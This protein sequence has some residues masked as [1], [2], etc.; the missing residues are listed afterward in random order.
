MT[1]STLEDE[2]LRALHDLR[3]VGT[4]AEAHLDAVC[5]VAANLFDVPIALVNLVDEATVWIKA[6]YGVDPA[7]VPRSDAFCHQTIEAV[8]GD[9]LVLP[10]LEKSERW[11][12][13]SLVRGGPNARF[14][15]GVPLALESGVNIGTLCIMDT[16]PR[17][18]FGAT[19][20]S[21]LYD[22]ASIVESH[23]RLHEARIARRKDDERYRL[24]ADNSTD[25]IIRS[26]LD[27]TRRYVSPAARTILSY[28][29]EDLLGGSPFEF[30]HPADMKTFAK[31]MDDLANARIERGIALQR[32]RH[33][34]GRWIWVE[35]TFSLTRDPITGIADG[36]VSSLRDVSDRIAMEEALRISEERLSLALD[37]GSD[38]L[39]DWNLK[40]GEVDLSGQWMTI[41]GYGPGDIAPNIRAWRGRLHLMTSLSHA[42]SWPPICVGRR[43]VSNANTGC[44]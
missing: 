5:R 44:G 15:A 43:I 37:S 9:A 18:D 2:R 35:V 19:E 26:D 23:F 21:G 31:N 3:I 33:K 29:P 24:L 39:W 38:G 27:A 28:D 40:T 25:L 30:I 20:S 42:N 11:R 32:Y 6:A 13:S 14:Y 1:H 22:L 12:G 41:L 4:P 7:P 16:V 8:S 34:D 10:D 17:P 36:F